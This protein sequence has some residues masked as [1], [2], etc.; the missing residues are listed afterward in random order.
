MIFTLLDANSFPL[1]EIAELYG[2]GCGF[3]VLFSIELRRDEPAEAK[4][5]A[6]VVI[7]VITNTSLLKT[8]R[9]KF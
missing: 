2:F 7:F 4:P 1:R 9:T 6:A 8:T 5:L 3:S